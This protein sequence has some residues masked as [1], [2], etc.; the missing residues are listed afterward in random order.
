MHEKWF[1]SMENTYSHEK[2]ALICLETRNLKSGQKLPKVAKRGQKWPK[3]AE[4]KSLP[5]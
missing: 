4:K 1:L 3:M 5:H 2:S